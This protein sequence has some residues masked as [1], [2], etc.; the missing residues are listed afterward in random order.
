MSAVWTKHADELLNLM[1][2]Q[3]YL[4]QLLSF[5]LDIQDKIIEDISSSPLCTKEEIVNI[6]TYYTM[7]ERNRIH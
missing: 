4:Q 7:L 5:P 6:M 1:N 3:K 2:E